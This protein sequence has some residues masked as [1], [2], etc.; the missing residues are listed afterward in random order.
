[1]KLPMKKIRYSLLIILVSYQYTLAQLQL[2]SGKMHAASGITVANGKIYST[3]PGNNYVGITSLSTGIISSFGAAGSGNA[4]FN[5]PYGITHDSNGKIYVADQNNNRIQVFDANGNF[6]TK[7]GTSGN[8]SGQ[9]WGPS[10]IFYAS[11]GKIYVGEKLNDRVQ[12]FDASYNSLYTFGATGSGDGLFND[13]LSIHVDQNQIIYTVDF[14][15]REIQMFDGKNN[16]AFIRRFGT[17]EINSSGNG[18]TVDHQTGTIYV[19]NYNNI[20]K[21][22]NNGNYLGSFAASSQNRQIYIDQLTHH[23]WIAGDTGN[24]FEYDLSGNL[25]ATYGSGAA[26]NA[27]ISSPLGVATDSQGNIV[28]ATQT[29]GNYEIKRYTAQGSYLNKFSTFVK[30]G[31]TIDASDNIYAVGNMELKKYSS[32][33]AVLATKFLG[34]AAESMALSSAGLF[35]FPQ[36]DLSGANDRVQVY[37]NDL[38]FNR[39]IGS[40]GTGDGQF[41]N[42]T[43]L[44]VDENSNL[45]V[46][47]GQNKT[48][49]K[50]N[51]A[52][53]F[54][55]KITF[56]GS[57]SSIAY[58]PTGHI[59]VAENDKI[60]KFDVNGNLITSFG[61]AGLNLGQFYR[62]R[63]MAYSNGNIIISESTSNRVMVVPPTPEIG[64]SLSGGGNVVSGGTIDIGNAPLGNSL[65]ANFNIV[66]QGIEPLQLTGNPKVVLSGAN[67]ADFT[68]D[69]PLLPT[70]LSG[71]TSFKVT[72]AG[73]NPGVRTATITIS[74]N[75]P[76]ESSFSFTITATSKQ[77]QTISN[78]N[79]IA[80]KTYGDQSFSVSADASSGLAV[81]FSSSNTSVATVSGNT[82][83][84]VGAGLTNIT[85]T[86]PG[87]S[88][89]NAA[90]EVV[91]P[92]VVNK[93]S[94]TA[95]AQNIS[96][97]Y[98][99]T[100]PAPN[101]VY[102]GF[103]NGDTDNVLDTKPGAT[104]NSSATITADAG[105]AHAITVQGGV[106]NNYAFTYQNG[107]L[108]ITK[109]SATVQIS[110]T[111]STY[112][113]TEKSVVVTT[114]P[115]S[116]PVV[117]K[118][119]NA[120][121]L[122][123]N[124]GSYDVSVAIDH[125]NYEGASTSTLVIAKAAGTI[126]MAARTFSYDG[127]AKSLSATTQPAGLLVKIE[128]KQND[129]IIIEPKTPG[130]YNVLAKIEDANSEVNT[131]SSTLTINK[132]NGTISLSGLNFTYDGTA[133]SATATI[134]PAGLNYIIEYKQAGVLVNEPKNAGSYEVTA[135]IQD[136]YAE[137][138]TATGIL[139]IAK[140]NQALTFDALPGKVFGD[141]DFNL[142]ASSSTLL[143]VIFES[144]N[145]SV[146]TITN[147]KV[148][149][150]KTGTATITAKQSGSANYNPT[151]KSQALVISKASQSISFASI[152]NK[153]D[154]SAPFNLNATST[155]GLPIAYEVVSGPATVSGNT[156]TLSKTLGT[157]TIKASQVGNENFAAAESKI[158]TFTVSLDV[159]AGIG[160]RFI[161]DVTVGPNPTHEVLNINLYDHKAKAVFLYD[162]T[163][164]VTHSIQFES[165]VS[166]HTL[167]V[168]G[169]TPGMYVVDIRTEQGFKI[170]SKVL[171][172]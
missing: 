18:V 32:T 160:E 13:L 145:T 64:V 125:K 63:F 50:F 77:E 130:V 150:V 101:I 84:I 104:I 85:A 2:G 138:T 161:G 143:P 158:Q 37:N 121:T 74:T 4:A 170:T 103:K 48:L 142:V 151:E 137:T 47:D 78:F 36:T 39:Y 11:D 22:D 9:L 99:S 59:Y 71:A 134:N 10:C 152:E 24:L 30:I 67:A 49:Q 52:D 14:S 26:S 27:D 91:R 60:K 146:A 34:L 131:A 169:L 124:A 66:S 96:R 29:S 106:D 17:T 87:N 53:V 139:E 15:N 94:L 62:P 100:N 148:H 108:T 102:S 44:V 129:Q 118:Y 73:T 20:L 155:S 72:Y 23:L 19:S 135:T 12:V 98:G 97:T 21:Y 86:Q 166:E 6:I 159:V 81:Q 35:Y 95:S 105:T 28:V 154:T 141:N 122:P 55:W 90:I 69:Q 126:Q 46:I 156:V 80:D 113:G 79:T 153:M 168:S 40:S 110:S 38:T 111:S 5:S 119:N 31:V 109:A 65:N 45:Y 68:I 61:S 16:G 107:Q 41:L 57:V 171:I 25:L 3:N 1:M 7:F 144:S 70:S 88:T 43:H 136:T 157:V 8:G 162:M 54:Q 147:G 116:L 89:Y 56:T 120:T 92:L 163:G 58:S 117:V 76:D 83:T 133:K 164:K 140:A 132:V 123:V 165:P 33:G 42:P 127:T 114:T 51:S 93:A 115:P 128:Y 75:D 167:N 112:T 82:I 149:I 172:N